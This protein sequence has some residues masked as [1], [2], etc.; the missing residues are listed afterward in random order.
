MLNENNPRY[1]E[2]Q[3]ENFDVMRKLVCFQSIIHR[4]AFDN[5]S[6]YI[7]LLIRTNFLNMR[8][9]EEITQVTP[10]HRSSR[11]IQI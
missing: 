10:L 2:H 5:Y 4:R 11:Y 1:Y 8:M 7:E 9:I 6:R 3:Y